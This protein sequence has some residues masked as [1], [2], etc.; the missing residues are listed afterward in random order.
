MLL[1]VGAM[2]ART[3][4]GA[5]LTGNDRAPRR[6]EDNAAAPIHGLC[7]LQ[8]QG[9]RKEG[10]SNL[11]DPFYAADASDDVGAASELS[12][13]QGRRSREGGGGTLNK[14]A[15]ANVGACSDAAGRAIW[16]L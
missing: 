5:A 14:Q 15:A 2:S 13:M 8:R 1:G 11:T 3:A 9:Q 16:R 6:S 12:E 4:D 10:A 7:K